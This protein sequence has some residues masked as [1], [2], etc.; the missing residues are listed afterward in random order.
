MDPALPGF[1]FS[2]YV[3][4]PEERLDRGDADFVDVIH[5][6]AGVLGM[7]IT[8][9]HADFFPNGGSPFQPGCKEKTLPTSTRKGRAQRNSDNLCYSVFTLFSYLFQRPAVMA[10]LTNFSRNPSSIK[11]SKPLAAQTGNILKI[12]SVRTSTQIW[13]SMPQGI[14]EALFT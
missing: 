4:V 8:V 6:C 9:G 14:S 12:K 7:S 2:T 11:I 3:K 13:A 1:Q 10:D 5:T